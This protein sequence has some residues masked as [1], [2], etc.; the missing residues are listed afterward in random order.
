MM[1]S[2]ERSS[3]VTISDGYELYP[4]PSPYIR[5][6]YM[7][8]VGGVPMI[9]DTR[10]V[11]IDY[12]FIQ[13]NWFSNEK[14]ISDTVGA[15]QSFN[16]CLHTQNVPIQISISLPNEFDDPDPSEMQALS[17]NTIGGHLGNINGQWS[18]NAHMGGDSNWNSFSMP[19][20]DWNSLVS[21][22]AD[23]LDGSLSASTNMLENLVQL[24]STLRMFRNPFGLLNARWSRSRKTLRELSKTSSNV[25]LEYRYGWLNFFRD[26]EAIA[27]CLE[28]ASSHI[29]YLQQTRSS[30]ASIGRRS[31]ETA[32][33]QVTS[34][35]LGDVVNA[36]S[37]T[38]SDPVVTRTCAFSLDIL[39][40]KAFSIL[41]RGHYVMDQL[42]FTDLYSALWDL[43]P[44]SFV[45]DWFIDIQNLSLE[46]PYLFRKWDLR[47][48]GYS[49]KHVWTASFNIESSLTAFQRTTTPISYTIPN[50]VVRSQYAR[51]PG[52]PASGQTVGLFGGFNFTHLMDGSALIMQGLR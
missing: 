43:L 46:A 47:R 3:G 23:G 10:D 7:E 1:Y 52:F 11:P 31:I 22:V 26:F 30:W 41:S 4:S 15:R 51:Y 44:F 12:P 21:Q 13:S 49:V 6:E 27:S 48:V 50:Q 17:W 36:L 2:R 16:S 9:T 33:Y 29:K 40:G 19:S 8:Y 20:P 35:N 14:S 42:K 32:S 24:R 37:I 45:V 38:M 25:W 28:R 39:R 5:Q 18:A 34:P